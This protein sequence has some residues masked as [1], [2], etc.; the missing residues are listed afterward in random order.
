MNWWD[1]PYRGLMDELRV[2][3]DVLTDL[4]VAELAAG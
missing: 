1:L 3:D 4:Q 2:Y